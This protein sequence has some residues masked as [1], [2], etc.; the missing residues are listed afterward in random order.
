MKNI[1][2]VLVLL[3]LL[4]SCG[5]SKNNTQTQSIEEKVTGLWTEHWK[6][7]PTA[8]ET[9]INYVDTLQLNMAKDGNVKIT[10]INNTYYTY[11]NINFDGI[12]LSFLMVNGESDERF[13]V[14]YD[15]KMV[16]DF[17]FKGGI[18][19]IRGKKALVELKKLIKK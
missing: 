10:C 11:E 13:T 7:D 12:N 4:F 8:E 6:S 3:V 15:L 18:V 5:G 17:S 2:T 19:N 14:Q 1:C 16:N 9:D